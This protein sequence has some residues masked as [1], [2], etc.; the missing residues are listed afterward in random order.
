MMMQKA[1]NIFVQQIKSIHKKMLKI[2][3]PVSK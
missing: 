3:K 2:L 1:G